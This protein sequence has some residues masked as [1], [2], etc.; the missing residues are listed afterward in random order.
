M[1][2]LVQVASVRKAL[3]TGDA[4]R[5][6]FVLNIM[7]G[8]RDIILTSH[9]MNDMNNYNEFCRLLFRFRATAP[10]NEMAE[11]P[12]Y[13][14]WIGLIADFTLKAIQSWK[15]RKTCISIALDH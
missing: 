13:I 2:C 11:K 10:L 6:K 15:V 3:F 8:T 12:G 14:E 1:E 5:A 4:E 9:G 7:K